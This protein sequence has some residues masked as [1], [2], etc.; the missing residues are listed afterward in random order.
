MSKKLKTSQLSVKTRKRIREF[1]TNNQLS[2]RDT[3]TLLDVPVPTMHAWIGNVATSKFP[4]PTRC[5]GLNAKLDEL[6]GAVVREEPNGDLKA[7]KLVERLFN[8]I[9]YVVGQQT[10]KRETAWLVE[11][12][13]AGVIKSQSDEAIY[14]LNRYRKGAQK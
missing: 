11:G 7:T 1:A 13:R 8:D 10:S 12:W 14:L 6:D 4:R 5:A 3:A 2:V 9:D